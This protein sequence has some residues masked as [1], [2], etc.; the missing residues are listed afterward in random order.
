VKEGDERKKIE[1]KD[2]E[3]RVVRDTL[4]SGIMPTPYLQ[5]KFMQSRNAIKNTHQQ[6]LCLLLVLDLLQPLLH[7]NGLALKL[8]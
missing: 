7:L 6:L 4:A 8:C 3:E 1:G 5:S 2:G